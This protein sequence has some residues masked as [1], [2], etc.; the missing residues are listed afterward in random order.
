MTHTLKA[1]CFRGTRLRTPVSVC[2]R[3]DRIKI[4][5]QNELKGLR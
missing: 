1:K 4:S 3:E 2:L 5:K